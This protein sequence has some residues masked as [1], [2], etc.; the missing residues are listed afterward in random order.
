M[1]L[2]R[3]QATNPSRVALLIALRQD[4]SVLCPAKAPIYS[5]VA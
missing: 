1:R 4:E 3:L 5:A 2:M